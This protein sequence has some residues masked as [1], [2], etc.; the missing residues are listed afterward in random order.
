MDQHACVQVVVMTVKKIFPL[1]K[2]STISV[3]VS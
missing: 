3:A 2:K 1:E